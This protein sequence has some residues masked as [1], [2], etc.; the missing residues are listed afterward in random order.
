MTGGLVRLDLTAAGWERRSM[1]GEPRLSEVVAAYRDAGFEVRLEDPE[2]GCCP[3]CT[4]QTGARV[5]YTRR[6]VLAGAVPAAG[7]RVEGA[8]AVPTVKPV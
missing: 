2:P 3:G 8:G 6:Q 1:H 7:A 5:V 4:A